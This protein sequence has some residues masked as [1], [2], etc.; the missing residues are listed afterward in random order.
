MFRFLP[1]LIRYLQ[2]FVPEESKAADLKARLGPFCGGVLAQT[3]SGLFLAD[4]EDWVVGRSLLMRGSWSGDELERIAPYLTPNSQVLVVGAHIGSLAIPIA[5]QVRRVVA[6]EAN[7]DTFRLLEWNVRL[8]GAD[9]VELHDYAASDQPGLIRFLL[10]RANSGGSKREPTVHATMYYYDNPRTIEVNAWPLDDKLAG[11]QF[12]FAIMDIEGSEYFALKGMTGILH[13]L[14]ALQIEYLPHHL[15][16]VAG[17]SPA[18]FSALLTPH[19]KTLVVPSL[20]LKVDQQDFSRV[21]TEMYQRNQ[22]DGGIL[23]EK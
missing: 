20:N 4:P 15:K 1:Q 7:P 6:I 16:N 18:Q 22:E 14:R 9:N 17:V 2:T 12:D 5:K 23:F 19:F 3:P 21:L 8:N 11:Q 13:G 10:S